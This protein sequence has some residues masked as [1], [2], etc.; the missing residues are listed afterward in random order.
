MEGSPRLW[1][2]GERTSN[3]YA[4]AVWTSS[5]I[6]S[7]DFAE[8]FDPSLGL[9]CFDRAILRCWWEFGWG[10]L[11]R[12]DKVLGYF[13]LGGCIAGSHQS[14]VAGLHESLGKDVEEEPPDEL[15][16]RYGYGSFP[17]GILIVTGEESYPVVV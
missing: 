5:Q 11:S 17:T 8:D 7:S 4:T 9:G 2:S 1:E 15:M 12:W 6:D 10:A 13:E 14:V 16:R 3:Q